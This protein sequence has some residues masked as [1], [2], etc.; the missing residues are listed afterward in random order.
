MRGNAWNADEP[1]NDAAH[2]G[3]NFLT[4]EVATIINAVYGLTVPGTP[5]KDLLALFA[6]DTLKVRTGEQDKD[7]QPDR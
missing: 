6:P 7:L 5:R 3:S 1:K 4:C 2:W